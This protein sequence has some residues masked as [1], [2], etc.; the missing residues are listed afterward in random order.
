MTVISESECQ[1]QRLALAFTYHGRVDHALQV[2]TA[3]SSIARPEALKRSANGGLEPP[4]CILIFGARSAASEGQ[5]APAMQLRDAQHGAAA[6]E[7]AGAR[8]R[9][10][11]PASGRGAAQLAEQAALGDAILQRNA[12]VTAHD[13]T[14]T[15][16]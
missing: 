14:E 5:R 9:A 8:R 11:R 1:R 7:R 10:A 2:Q 16:I 12:N 15:Q 6:R 13:P 3:Q 4:V